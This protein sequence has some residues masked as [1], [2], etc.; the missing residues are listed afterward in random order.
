MHDSE[1]NESICVIDLL[2]TLESINVLLGIASTVITHSLLSSSA[3]GN[4]REK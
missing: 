4:D 1:E 3:I 2:P